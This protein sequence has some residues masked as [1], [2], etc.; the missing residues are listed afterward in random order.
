MPHTTFSMKYQPSAY[1]THRLPGAPTHGGI[2]VLEWE[3]VVRVIENVFCGAILIGCGVIRVPVVEAE[4]AGR[5]WASCSGLYKVDLGERH[6]LLTAVTLCAGQ[7]IN[8]L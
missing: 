6:R 2:D 5:V 3:G 4:S 7:G 1:T 8:Q